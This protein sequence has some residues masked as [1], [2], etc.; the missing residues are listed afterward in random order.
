MSKKIPES[1]KPPRTPYGSSD[2][3][4]RLSVQCIAESHA[5]RPW[6][7]ASFYLEPKAPE[8]ARWASD[9]NYWREGVHVAKLPSTTYT[10]LVGDR[11]VSND[12]YKADPLVF[13]NGSRSRYS[14]RCPICGLSIARRSEVV[15]ETFDRLANAGVSE[16]S[17]E[18]LAAILR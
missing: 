18:S 16:I 14:F 12:E 3:G 1:P 13:D 2:D 10:A 17:L 5:E 9:K 11:V 6:L 7:V 15:L 4:I 8:A